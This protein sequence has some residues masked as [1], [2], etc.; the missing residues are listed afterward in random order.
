[1]AWL[2]V[3][4]LLAA[5][6]VGCGNQ[7]LPVVTPI[8][9]TGPAGQPIAYVAVTS[10]PNF[11][12]LD[13]P[14]DNPCVPD[15]AAAYPDP[16][17]AT[18][19]D[20]SGDSIAA[21]ALI[22]TGPV[23][24][25]M[26]P[27]GGLAYAPNCDG[28]ISAFNVDGSLQTKDVLTSTLINHPNAAVP[29][30]ILAMSG[31]IFTV[32]EGHNAVAEMSSSAG[33]NGA[34]ALVQE[35][36][37]APSLINMVGI[38]DAPRIYAISQG[39]SNGGTQPAWG[40]C[41]NPASVTTD[42][43]A[44][45]IDLV[46]SGKGKN[47]SIA[48]QSVSSRIPLGVCPVYG[49]MSSNGERAFIMNRGSGTVTVIDA[50]KNTIDPTNN[51]Y[52]T[53]NGTI[54]L[55][56][57]TTPCNAGPVFAEIYNNGQELVT[58]NYDNDTISVI[59]ISQDI[60]GNDS[61]TF[62]KVLAT[63]PVGTHP[64]AL[65]ILQDGSRV[66]VADQGTTSTSGSTA[67]YNNDGAVTIA[68]LKSFSVE[69]SIPIASNPRMIQSIYNYPEGKVFVASPNSPFLTVIRTDTDT[70]DSQ[71]EVQGNITGISAS[72]QYAGSSA[73]VLT[74]NSNID[75]HAPGSGEP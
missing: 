67:A 7:Y 71:V 17:V 24:T 13:V 53:G 10:E 5:F 51:G 28:T 56:G 63:I 52:L 12:L 11:N 32:E 70:V 39:N 18:I 27:T 59:D 33:S 16:G 21:Q 25:A 66:Y 2:A 35:I 47:I 57:G 37:V 30:N 42:G 6:T 62:G 15:P 54:N 38:N 69:K 75:S 1:M 26:D 72:T 4:G 46:I 9:P 19:V 55:C 31:T 68:S 60:Y 20:F 29:Y 61:P 73:T 43:E 64:A 22:G 36:P 50:Q 3:C 45:G 14:Q 8:N 40:A 44:D 58:A 48:N 74:S 65:T 49:V 23:I 34:P 41:S